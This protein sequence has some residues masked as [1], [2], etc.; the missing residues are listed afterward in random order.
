MVETSKSLETP[1][2]VLGAVARDSNAIG[3]SHK[4]SSF[5]G[6]KNIALNERNAGT[7]DPNDFN[8]STEA[9]PFTAVSYT[10]LD[11]YK[12]QPTAFGKN[13]IKFANW[14]SFTD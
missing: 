8:I 3:F 2:D 9:Y 13:C 11:V 5:S 10:H 1:D 7:F 14:L 12:R 4:P 6:V